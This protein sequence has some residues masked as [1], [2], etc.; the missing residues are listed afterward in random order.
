MALSENL[1]VVKRGEQ[2]AANTPWSWHPN[3]LVE[4]Q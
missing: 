3:S 2:Q 4:T 1:W